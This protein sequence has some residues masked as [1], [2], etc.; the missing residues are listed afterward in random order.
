MLLH[1]CMKFVS[2]SHRG[3]MCMWR[4]PGNPAPAHRPKFIPTLKPRGFIA[5]ESAFCDSLMS[6]VN[7]NSSSSLALSSS[8]MCR[9]GAISK[10]P[11]LYG[12]RFSTTML[13][14]ER[15]ST[16]FLSSSWG[17]PLISQMK[18]PLLRFKPW[19]YLI[20]HGAHIFP[21]FV[22]DSSIF[23][24]LHCQSLID[25]YPRFYTK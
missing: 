14:S 15:H 2:P 11:L 4:C 19:T 12:K 1:T 5:N 24:K 23:E 21:Y 7:S 8:G 9:V 22:C 17:L 16:R 10:W 18:Q 20:R 6:L 25:G 13:L 3:T